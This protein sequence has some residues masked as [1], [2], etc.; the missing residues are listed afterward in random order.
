M[1][2]PEKESRELTPRPA[3]RRPLVALPMAIAALL[4]GAAAADGKPG[5]HGAGHGHDRA[6]RLARW[7]PL[8]R[9]F[10]GMNFSTP[11]APAPAVPPGPP[12][13]PW[14]PGAPHP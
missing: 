5:A 7:A 1:P 14:P 2:L 6:A 12:P 13:A 10:I 3:T 9:A 11:F 8:P 4:L